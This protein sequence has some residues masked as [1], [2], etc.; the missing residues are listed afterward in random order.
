MQPLT[1]HT[2]QKENTNGQTLTGIPHITAQADY[3][4]NAFG[5]LI[6]RYLYVTAAMFNIRKGPCYTLLDRL[7]S[8]THQTNSE[9]DS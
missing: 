5:I 4:N 7:L 1:P 9:R 8:I 2:Q 3:T 6:Q